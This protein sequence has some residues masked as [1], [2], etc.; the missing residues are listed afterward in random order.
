MIWIRVLL[1]LSISS[2]W[3]CRRTFLHFLFPFVQI[4][5]SFS[6]LRLPVPHPFYLA[7]A[8]CLI[9]L[10]SIGIIEMFAIQP[11]S[12]H[13]LE[14]PEATLRMCWLVGVGEAPEGA[15][16]FGWWSCPHVCLGTAREPWLLGFWFSPWSGSWWGIYPGWVSKPFL[17]V[18]S[19]MKVRPQTIQLVW[20]VLWPQ[21]SAPCIPCHSLF[22]LISTFSQHWEYKETATCFF[23]LQALPHFPCLGY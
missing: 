7:N 2:L 12:D 11:R 6:C 20:L 3:E 22:K 19:L 17:I 5:Y 10:A 15:S 4:A 13:E 14:Q 18:L 21:Q 8:L 23:G 1:W 9:T 16:I